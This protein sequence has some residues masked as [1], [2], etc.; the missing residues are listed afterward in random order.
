MQPIAMAHGLL[1][2]LGETSKV[3]EDAGVDITI[4]PAFLEIQKV[5]QARVAQCTHAL[6][7]FGLTQEQINERIMR[8]H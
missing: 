1:V 7:G 2:T 3:L 8:G 5:T 6:V 4:D